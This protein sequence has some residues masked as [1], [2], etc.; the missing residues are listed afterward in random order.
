MRQA[1]KRHC[2]LAHPAPPPSHLRVLPGIYKVSSQV[3][4]SASKAA[5]LFLFFPPRD[6][7]VL[8]I[9]A[10]GS[11]P[12]EQTAK[13]K[14]GKEEGRQNSITEASPPRRV[15]R[16]LRKQMPGALIQHGSGGGGLMGTRLAWHEVGEEERSN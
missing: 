13:D 1:D 14:S 8:Q 6:R 12:Y 15:R 2:K 4:T 10:D 16:A 3:L 9:Q 11:L 5:F 7:R